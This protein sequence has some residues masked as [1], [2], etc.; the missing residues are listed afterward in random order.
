M[1]QV[2]ITEEATLPSN[3]TPPLNEAQKKQQKVSN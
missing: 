2:V 3:P 1:N